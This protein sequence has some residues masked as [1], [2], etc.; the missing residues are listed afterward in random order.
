ML[1]TILSACVDLY[2]HTQGF[3][4]CGLHLGPG[5]IETICQLLAI[6]CL[7]HVQIRQLEYLQIKMLFTL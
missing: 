5:C 1:L 3:A 2:E 6:N 4:G 7:D